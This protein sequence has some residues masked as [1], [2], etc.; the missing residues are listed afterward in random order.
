MIKR[1]TTLSLDTAWNTNLK[2]RGVKLPKRGKLRL[3]LF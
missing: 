3:Q 1:M 2:Q